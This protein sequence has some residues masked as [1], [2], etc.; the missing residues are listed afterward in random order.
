MAKSAKRIPSL[1]D[2][3]KTKKRENCRVCKLDV[4]V[5]GQI[6]RS[7]SERKISRDQQVEWVHLVTGVKITVEELTQHVNGRHDA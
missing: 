6:G 1:V 2:F 7:A 5:R 4:E 3:V